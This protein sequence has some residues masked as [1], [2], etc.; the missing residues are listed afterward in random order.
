MSKHRI[1]IVEDD[2]IIAEDTKR[3][4]HNLG[5]EVTS[6]SPSAKDALTQLKDDLPDLVL[7][8]IK[9]NGKM[10]GTELAE[11]IRRDF[12]IPVVYVTAYAD[13]LT[14]QKIKQTEPY[15]FIV[16]PYENKELQGVIEN[17]IYKHEMERK[18]RE[19]ESFFKTIVETS[20]HGIQLSDL[21]GKITLSNLAHQKILGRKEH[22]I[23]GK[24]VWDFVAGY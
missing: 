24:C 12:Y 18:L 8:D 4:L 16:K 2:L 19:S 11:R 9:L 1:L 21:K 6:I 17:A 15:G 3:T 23:I 20:P 14:L 5:Y 22:E 10:D 7:M 13:E